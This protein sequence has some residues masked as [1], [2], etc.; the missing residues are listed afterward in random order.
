MNIDDYRY[1]LTIADLG[2]FTKAAQKLFIAQPSL[3]QRVKHIEKSYGISIFSRNAKGVELTEEG[4]CFVRYA[5]AILN[6]ESDLRRELDDMKSAGSRVLRIGTTQFIRS[7]LFDSLVKR[8]HEEHP[9]VQ[10]EISDSSSRQQQEMLL[11]GKTDIAI[12][13]LPISSP[14]LKYEI[15]FKDNYVLVPAKDGLL[16]KRIQKRGE[17]ENEPVPVSMLAEEPLAIAPKGTRLNDYVMGLSEKYDTEFDIQHFVKNYA[18]LYVLAE[19]G[20]ASTILY[21][22][23][24]DPHQD[25]M[26]YYYLDDSTELSIAVVWR[27][28]AYLQQ[29]A[30]DLIRIA[31]EINSLPLDE[32][33]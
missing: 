22:S 7:Y 12:C 13:Y 17:L 4:T 9:E 31:K 25:Y 19:T 11:S 6:N 1:I 21:E 33:Y 23:F 3:S 8:F 28:G 24:F 30:V 16:Q 2:S 14:E 20:M 18:M 32:V 27:K 26:P 15:I 10:F 29:E 5:Q